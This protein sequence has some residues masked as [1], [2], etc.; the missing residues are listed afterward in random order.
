[1]LLVIATA[2]NLRLSPGLALMEGCGKVGQVARLRLVQSF[3]GYV[4]FWAI[5][6]AGMGLWSIVAMPIAS[7]I[8]TS[9]WLKTHGN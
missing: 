9:Y 2:F 3:L 1:M 4:S 8:C 6:F 5:L 7:A